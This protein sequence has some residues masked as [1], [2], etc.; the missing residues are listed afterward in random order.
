MYILAL[1]CVLPDVGP[2]GQERMTP[3]KSPG[4]ERTTTTTA[5][6]ARNS[7][8]DIVGRVAYGGERVVIERRGR[9]VAALISADDL[10]NL[11]DA[12]VPAGPSKSD[13]GGGWETV[14]HSA[15]STFF[16]I[17]FRRIHHPD[18]HIEYDFLEGDTMEIYGVSAEEIMTDSRVFLDMIHPS[19]RPDYLAALDRSLE[20]REPF[21]QVFQITRPDGESRWISTRAQI[22]SGSPEG[23]VWLGVTIDITEQKNAELRLSESR[24]QFRD[25]AEAASDYFWEVDADLRYRSPVTLDGSG[26]WGHWFVPGRTPY[27]LLGVDLDIDTAWASHLDDIRNRRP[28][29]DL[30]VTTRKNGKARHWSVSAKPV[31][32]A[33]GTFDGYRG[34]SRDI[35]DM[36]TAVERAD[37][38]ERQLRDVAANIPGLVYRRVL[39]PDGRIEFPFV[40][41][42]LREN[43]G[44]D[45]EAIMADPTVLLQ[46]LHPDDRQ[47]WQEAVRNSAATLEPFD[48]EVRYLLEDGTIRWSHSSSRPRALTDGT[49]VWDGVG[50]DITSQ[51]EAELEASDLSLQLG[52]VLG[53]SPIEFYFIDP[54]TLRILDANPFACESL[55][56]SLEEIRTLTLD[57]LDTAYDPTYVAGMVEQIAAGQSVQTVFEAMLR[58]KN[59]DTYPV[60]FRIR[61]ITH[62]GRPVIFAIAQSILERR[63]REFERMEKNLRVRVLNQTLMEL[64]TS[65]NVATGRFSDAVREITTMSARALDV[66]RSGIWLFSD[67]RQQMVC[68][69]IYDSQNLSHTVLP[70]MERVDF[71][72]FFDSLEHDRSVASQDALADSRSIALAECYFEPNNVQSVLMVPIRIGGRVVGVGC[73]ETIESERSWSVED[74]NFAASVGDIVAMAVQSSSR[75]DAEE[76][77]RLSEQRFRD[78]ADVASDWFWEMDADLRFTYITDQVRQVAGL[79]PSRVV[80]K[81]RQEIASNPSGLETPEWTAHFADL[82]ARRP[83]K[84]FQYSYTTANGRQYH[85]NVSGK[86]IFNADGE[87]T[88]YRGT[89]TD[90]T[91]AVKAR[92]AQQ[93]AHEQAE[94]ANRAKSEFLANMS[95]ELRTPLNAIIGFSEILQQETFGPIA[96]PQYQGYITD[97][98]E[99][100]RHLLSLINDILDLSKVEAGKLELF[101]EDIALGGVFEACR[102]LVQ[103]RVEASGLQSRFDVEEGLPALRCDERKIKQVLLNLLSNAIK[104][105]HEGGTVQARAFQNPAGEIT[106]E[107]EDSGIGI[108]SEDIERILIPFEQAASSMTRIHEGSGLGLPLARSLV[109]SHGGKL[110]ISSEPGKGTVAAISFPAARS[111]AHAAAAE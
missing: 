62:R 91:N 83:F 14:F 34:T 96:V 54:Y 68:Q 8:A 84:G 76:A 98:L 60:E 93:M 99:S 55:G 26:A 79:D 46:C 21:E 65:Q 74:Q 56:Y 97:I 4:P 10:E 90:V 105:S 59:G 43:F 15:S 87:F 47:A 82:A 81:T 104:F 73:H 64:A 5:T 85:V 29:R 95:H 102:K 111:S 11:H 33:D 44:A 80:G 42:G 45:P 48:M 61:P 58:R 69:D 22:K 31:F 92:Q 103:H 78:I 41:E 6:E 77:I 66:D 35:T 71:E 101:E 24:A 17:L 36:V 89:G 28:Y 109:E 32:L 110:T 13:D 86:P 53:E 16:G 50:L 72:N 100:G 75:R 94:L 70:H 108:A 52:Q 37:M 57:T 51:R 12:G 18:G 1:Y 106:I 67:D 38:A 40:S 23:N 27:E 107:V 39:H 63:T 7:F 25:F 20:T 3:P 19:S 9:P 49:I 2:T 30:H 88:G